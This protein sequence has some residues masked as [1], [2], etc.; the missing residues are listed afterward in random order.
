QSTGD[1]VLL[2]RVWPGLRK[3]IDLL[4]K[5]RDQDGNGLLNW[6]MGANAFL[7]QADHLEMPGD[8]AS[9]SIMMGA[10]LAK[11]SSIAV[12]IG[13][14]QDAML[15][16]SL[17]DKI[18]ASLSQVLWSKTEGAFYNHRDQ[19]GLFHR[20][21][22]YTDLVYPVLYSNMPDL[23]SWQS[24]NYL[25]R[26]LW[27]DNYKGERSLMRVG[28]F[29][30]SI[31]GNDNVMPVQMAEASRAYFKLGENEKGIRLMESVAL[32]ATI[33]TEA[34]GNFPERMNDEGKGEANYLFGNPIGSFL[35]TCVDGLFGLRLK[36]GGKT[37]YC[38]PAFPEEWNDASIQLPFASFSFTRTGDKN[39]K[40]CIYNIVQ[41]ENRKTDFS[42]LLEPFKWV[43]VFSNGKPV[44]F[45]TT[46]GINKTRVSFH[47]PSALKQQITIQYGVAD[48]WQDKDLLLKPG[49]GFHWRGNRE[50]EKIA[51]PQSVLTSFQIKDNVINGVTGTDTGWHV[52][53]VW[54][55]QPRTVQPLRI[56]IVSP[57]S[58]PPAEYLKRSFLKEEKVIPL[59][60][61]AWFNTDSFF[62]ASRW[63][64]E[65][66]L[67]DSNYFALLPDS[68]RKIFEY[69]GYPFRNGNSMAMICR[70]ISDGFTTET[71]KVDWP[72]S[73]EFAV[74]RK[75]KMLSFLW[76]CET[77]ARNTAM[78]VG[79]ITLNYTDGS[80]KQI[81]LKTG[82]NL[83][84]SWK[85]FA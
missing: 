6:H 22:Y 70:G 50:I 84:A 59:D 52:L 23:Y 74:G 26:F 66:E 76:A 51:D 36:D 55:K 82:E 30:P 41:A 56:H 34:P 69:Y 24:M 14:T 29:K 58:Q 39:S 80:R 42:V 72:D 79:Y 40:K 37:I 68:S 63:R 71:R 65:Y 77:Q 64:Y 3:S 9:P 15:W 28:E 16:K 27:T 18:T 81:H 1:R 62:L 5:L 33:F 8:A 83:D 48:L 10:M 46:A 17:S 67:R 38:E 73:M 60:I 12:Q 20:A 53:Y 21:R 54:T 35:Y 4:W 25:T 19:Q 49:E 44:E 61:S 75:L 32:A 2:E 11:L 47:L 7:Y 57:V 31:F 45:E 13:Q 43:K 78:E 85:Y